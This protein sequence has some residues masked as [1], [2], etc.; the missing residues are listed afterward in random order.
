MKGLPYGSMRAEDWPF[1]PFAITNGV[2][3]SMTLG[4]ALAGRPEPAGDY[5][6]YCVSNGVFRTNTFPTP[7]RASASHALKQV[8]ASPAWKALKWE[9]SGLGWSYSLDEGYAR[10]MLWK[11]VENMTNKTGS[12]RS[13]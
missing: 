12:A 11:Q 9:D 1:L 4:Y 10:E 6:T 13:R 3:L 8:L 5:L 2:P 7:S